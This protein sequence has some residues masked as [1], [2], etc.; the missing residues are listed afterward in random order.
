MTRSCCKKQ[1]KKKPKHF[2]ECVLE[3]QIIKLTKRFAAFFGFQMKL[4]P[5]AGDRRITSQRLKIRND[6]LC[7]S[8]LHVTH[9]KP[10]QSLTGPSAPEPEPEPDPCTCG[11]WNALFLEDGLSGFNAGKISQNRLRRD[12]FY[13]DPTFIPGLT[14]DL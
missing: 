8:F 5:H 6:S 7:A 9:T 1:K 3:S 2:E 10:S 11:R 13:S 4:R 14:F 12:H